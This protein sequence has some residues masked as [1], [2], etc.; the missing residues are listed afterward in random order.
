MELSRCG[1]GPPIRVML[2]YYGV[3]K[4]SELPKEKYEE[5]YREV[6]KW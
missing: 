4:L 6:S 5:L 2:N 3:K 1:M